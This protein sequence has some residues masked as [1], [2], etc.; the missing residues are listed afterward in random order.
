MGLRF[1]TCGY[2]VRL[3]RFKEDRE[4]AS[5]RCAAATKEDQ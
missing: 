2:P 4:Q 5:Q 1:P 3:R